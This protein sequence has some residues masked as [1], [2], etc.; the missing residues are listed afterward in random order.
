MDDQKKDH[1]NSKGPKQKNRSKQ[2]QTH[3]LSTDDEENINSTNKGK[4][5]LESRR[6]FLEEQKGCRKGSR[7]TAELLHTDQHILMRAKPDGKI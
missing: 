5:L 2:L 7:G 4:D 3:N 6:L 1:I